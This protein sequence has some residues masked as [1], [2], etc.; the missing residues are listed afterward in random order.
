MDAAVI[1]D[2]SASCPSAA[3]GADTVR[4]AAAVSPP[5]SGVDLA[6][7]ALQLMELM[8]S[9]QHFADSGPADSP[10]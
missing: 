7:A 6:A 3:G 4:S 9:A 2:M 5:I 8:P 1:A 10:T